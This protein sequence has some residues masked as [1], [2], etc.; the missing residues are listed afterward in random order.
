MGFGGF[1]RSVVERNIE[2]NG[3]IY[4]FSRTQIDKFGQ[5][6]DGESTEIELKGLYHEQTS[7]LQQ[8]KT[9][10]SVYNKRKSPMI[11]TLEDGALIC[12]DDKVTIEGKVFKVVGVSDVQHSGTV[13][14]IS[15]EQEVTGDGRQ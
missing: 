3:K 15:L 1:Y 10:G 12:T 13:Y 11:L 7:Y 8:H 4:R 5:P 6:I 2:T 14:D 9:D